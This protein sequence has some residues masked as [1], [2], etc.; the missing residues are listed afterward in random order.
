MPPVG[1]DR[2]DPVFAESGGPE[3]FPG[4]TWGTA[5]PQGIKVHSEIGG[6]PGA[7]SG[8]FQQAVSL[9][10]ELTGVLPARLGAQTTSHTTAFAKDAE[11]QRGA[12]RTVDYVRQSGQGP[13]TRWLDMAYTMGRDSLSNTEE[14]VFFIDSY[15]GFVKI[16]KQ[17]LP[18]KA[19]FEWFG[20]GGPAEQQQK[21]QMRLGAL[22][23]GLKMDQLGAAMG[24]PPKIDLDAAIAEVLREGG[25]IDIDAIT[26]M[27]TPQQPAGPAAPI[28]PTPT[29]AAI[30][31]L[32]KVA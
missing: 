30:Q 15:G 4:A 31:N 10:A 24:K 26:K 17:A 28:G 29:V 13:L 11:L 20:S 14:I 3:I 16:D 18:D 32:S 22:Q 2:T 23:L 21:Q 19:S 12:V 1:W 25:W 27:Q 7:L 5:D 6:D 9:Y 8:I